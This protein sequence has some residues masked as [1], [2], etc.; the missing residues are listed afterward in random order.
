MNL[1]PCKNVELMQVNF[2]RR[3]ALRALMLLRPVFRPKRAFFSRPP[4]SAPAMPA[5]MPYRRYSR[6]AKPDE[7][8]RGGNNERRGIV[9]DDLFITASPKHFRVARPP[10]VQP[11]S[12]ETMHKNDPGKIASIDLA[13][14]ERVS[15]GQTQL[16][17]SETFA[18]QCPAHERV[19]IFLLVR[20]GARVATTAARG[21]PCFHS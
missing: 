4:I 19:P 18:K 6:R 7:P 13:Q 12:S 1:E 8:P 20:G 2:I 14:R 3:P 15:I 21:L 5:P 9:L 17:R 10:S 11:A 16:R